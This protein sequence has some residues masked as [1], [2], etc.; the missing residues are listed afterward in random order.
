M[1]ELPSVIPD[2]ET[3][4]ALEPEELGAKL[5]FVLGNQPEQNIILGNLL[6]ELRYPSTTGQQYSST[7]L[8]AVERAVVEAW[9]WL[10]AQGLIVPAAGINGQNGWRRLSRRAGRYKDETEFAR[11]ETARLLPKERLH[12]RIADKVWS[13]FVRGDFDV[14]VFQAMKGVEVY[15][16]EV[17]N[18]GNDLLGTVLMQ[19]A[20]KKDGGALTDVNAEAGERIGRMNLFTGAIA[21]YKNPNSHRDVDLNDPHEALEIISLANHLMRIIDARARNLGKE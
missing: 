3:L 9:A 1:R 2:A 20:F 5:L 4:L 16:R 13:A 6:S 19:E 12:A 17:G 21:S 18:F 8:D 15:V 10:E 14:A 11:M 7:Q